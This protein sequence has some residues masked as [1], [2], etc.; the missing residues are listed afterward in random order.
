MHFAWCLSGVMCPKLTIPCAC[1]WAER[2][3]SSYPWCTP[4]YRADVQQLLAAPRTQK[5]WIAGTADFVWRHG[6]HSQAARATIS[7]SA[8]HAI[9][10]YLNDAELLP[11]RDWPRLQA[12]LHLPWTC[13]S[14]WLS[15]TPVSLS[16]HIKQSLQAIAAPT[17]LL[18]WS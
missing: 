4:G 5:P 18:S 1:S 8:W 17:L 6:Q 12:W 3:G 7:L 9:N 15:Q 10:A 2:S 11:G 13:L 16:S 14:Q